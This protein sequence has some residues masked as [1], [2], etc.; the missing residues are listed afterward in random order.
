MAKELALKMNIDVRQI[1][2]I[3]AAAS[4]NTAILSEFYGDIADKLQLSSLN[5]LR[6]ISQLAHG[7]TECLYQLSQKRSMIFNISEPD[8]F[9]AVFNITCIGKRISNNEIT[10]KQAE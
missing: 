2:P 5:S 6:F 3:L 7:Q 1:L 8:L 9:E 10:I 4:G